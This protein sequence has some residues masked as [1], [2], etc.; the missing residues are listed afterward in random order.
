MPELPEVETIR[1]DL[2]SLVSGKMI[3]E[4]KV[5]LPKTLRSNR[6]EFKNY[7][8]GNTIVSIGR[9]GKILVFGF[10][11]GDLKLL[12]HLKMTGQLIFEYDRRITAGGHG[13]SGK[14]LHLPG[15]H[16]RV[17]II[18]KDGSR[19]FFNDMRQFGYMKLVAE[20]ELVIVK[21]KFGPEPFDRDFRPEY[22]EEKLKKRSISI[23]AALLDQGLVA[24]IGNIYADEI[25]FEAGIRPDRRSNSLS[26]AEIKKLHQA[27]KN[28]IRQA[29]KYRGTTFNDYVD[30][31]GRTGTYLSRLKVYGREKME[32]RCGGSIQKT[33][34]AGRGTR[35]CPRCQ[36]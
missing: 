21:Q 31:R 22:L 23:K 17:V 33:R 2:S 7:L 34:L 8:T 16:T 28:I 32:C 35:F 9:V 6:S 5:I 18:F 20:E 15:K 29:I 4:A 24:G 11:R 25:C 30:A 3:K 26:K 12:V 19:L 27:A 36:K 10:V 14:E 1:N 13:K